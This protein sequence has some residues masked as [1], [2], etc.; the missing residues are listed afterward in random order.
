MAMRREYRQELISG[1]D[2]YMLQVSLKSLPFG[3]AAKNASGGCE[4]MV[5]IGG[6]RGVGQNGGSRVQLLVCI[7]GSR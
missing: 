5:G 7:V 1:F 3:F 4:G 6:V 2:Q